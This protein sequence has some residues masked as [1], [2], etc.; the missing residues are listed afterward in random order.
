M[1]GR[2]L[3]AGGKRQ[4]NRVR[5][6]LAASACIAA[7]VTLLA[8]AGLSAGVFF[9]TQLRYSDALFPSGGSDH[10][11]VVVAIDDKS[12]AQLGRWPWDR[13]APP[14]LLLRPGAARAPLVRFHG[15]SSQPPPDHGARP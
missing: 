2:L 15:T 14:R 13:R 11:I 4:M 12:L 8:W 5:F 6:R 9:G 7:A 3:A 1:S 10:R